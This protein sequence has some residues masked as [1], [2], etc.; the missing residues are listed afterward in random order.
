MELLPRRSIVDDALGLHLVQAVEEQANRVLDVQSDRSGHGVKRNDFRLA[1]HQ[2]GQGQSLLLS[3]PRTSAS[4]ICT[5]ILA[6]NGVDSMTSVT[7]HP[8]RLDLNLRKLLGVC[9]SLRPDLADGRKS[10]QSPS[11]GPQLGR[12]GSRRAAHAGTPGGRLAAYQEARRRPPGGALAAITRAALPSGPLVR[13]PGRATTAMRTSAG[14]LPPMLP[15]IE[16][17]E[18][19]GAHDP[20]EATPG[21]RRQAS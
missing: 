9:G 3:G 5:T 6:R 18:I 12:G 13:E 4:F 14:D 16:A 19:V 20:D 10:R 17:R 7:I 8:N 21:Q 11:V 15:A 1:S 2:S